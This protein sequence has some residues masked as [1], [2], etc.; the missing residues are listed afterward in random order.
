MPNIVV[1]VAEF[2]ANLSKF[3]SESRAAGSQIVITSRKKPIATVVP[4]T[5]EGTDT[6]PGYVG[7]ASIAGTWTDFPKISS[8]IEY[9]YRSR[10]DETYREISL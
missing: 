7:L 10:Q 4:Y 1:S 9:A 2:K 3:L 8:D 6:P 5:G